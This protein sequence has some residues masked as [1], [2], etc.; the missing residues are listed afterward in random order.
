MFPDGDES[1][2]V[3][4]TDRASKGRSMA[5]KDL[6]WIWTDSEIG[7]FRWENATGERIIAALEPECV[8][9]ARSVSES[10]KGSDQ[11]TW[12]SFVNSDYIELAH[13]WVEQ[14]ERLRTRNFT[15]FATDQCAFERLCSWGIPCVLLEIG[16]ALKRLG[17]YR[18]KN[19]FEPGG[20]VLLVA[21]MLIY[22]E[23]VSG[24]VSI[25]ACD[26]D[27]VP[28]RDFRI[29]T[30]GLAFMGFQRV[31][32][33]PKVIV[34]LWGFA[35]CGGFVVF[36]ACEASVKVIGE[37]L[38][39]LARF[40]DD[41]LALN[42]ALLALDATWPSALP[43]GWNHEQRVTAFIERAEQPIVGEIPGLGELLALPATEFWRHKFVP[44]DRQRCV[45]MHPNSPKAA[46]RKLEILN[47]LMR[48]QVSTE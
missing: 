30:L 23:L 31:V 39:F 42:L 8:L 26:L 5:D 24:G 45:I 35:L 25:V 28:L 11:E 29:N 6:K 20:L 7:A 32:Y 17:D 43:E 21:R 33:F 15:I 40:A 1:S 3:D 44:F 2:K 34:G 37:A 14:L 19:G 4:K 22:R 9:A 48:P 36:R 16:H 10:M 12:I 46:D 13:L 27:A 47:G 38:R 41:Q 18:N